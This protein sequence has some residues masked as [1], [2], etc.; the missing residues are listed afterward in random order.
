MQL[1]QQ[2]QLCLSQVPCQ[3]KP[4][5][6]RTDDP[7]F[8]LMTDLCRIASKEAVEDFLHRLC[9][10]GWSVKSAEGWLLLDHP[11]PQPEL[12]LPP[13]FPGE[14]GCCLQLL[15]QHPSEDAPPVLLRQ[16]VKAAEM[17]NDKVE[18]LC[19]DWHSHF[20]ALLRQHQPLPAG[21]LPYLCAAMKEDRP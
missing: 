1:R 12:A 3:R 18:K 16:L 10:L 19:R 7:S 4:A 8:L 2:V 9:D 11:I 5:L 21:L 15:S 17:G 13:V 14:W 6:R 20:A